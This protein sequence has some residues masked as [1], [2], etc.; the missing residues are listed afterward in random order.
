M[1]KIILASASERRKELLG[2]LIGNTFEIRISSYSEDDV[3]GLSPAELAMHH[4]REKA[5][6]VA[7]KI[8]KCIV[9]SADTFVV[10]GDEVLGKPY[11]ADHARKMLQKINGCR[12]QVITGITLMDTTSGKE[13]T[14]FELTD[15]WMKE[16]SDEL[17][18]DY[19]NTGEPMGKAG[20]FAIQGKGA[21]LVKRI[22]GDFFNVVGLPLFRLSG[23]FE[24]FGIKILHFDDD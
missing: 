9:L 14:E 19:V 13:I 7:G 17:I 18:D 20:A 23:M 2:Q 21:I 10:L 11:D 3:A 8:G 24:E 1:Q 22:E 16:I 15:V 5:H 4:S 6:D 12:V